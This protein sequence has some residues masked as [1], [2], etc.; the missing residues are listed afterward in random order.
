MLIPLWFKRKLKDI[1]PRA[2]I[3]WDNHYHYFNIFIPVGISSYSREA[4]RVIHRKVRLLK[5]CYPEL[6]DAA[7]QDLEQRHWIAQ[8]YNAKGDKDAYMKK[9]ASDNN[10][11]RKKQ[12]EYA[13]DIL[14]QASKEFGKI[15]RDR[16]SIVMGG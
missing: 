4:G 8:R 11:A 9:I 12:K 13:M 2:E 1:D 7:M 14:N 10:T 15:A 3:E 5:G 16:K 6:N